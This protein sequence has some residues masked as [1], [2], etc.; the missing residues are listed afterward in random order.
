MSGNDAR[1]A[2]ASE[3]TAMFENSVLPWIRGFYLKQGEKA[4]RQ[5]CIDYCTLR[6]WPES[7]WPTVHIPASFVIDNDPRHAAMRQHIALPRA[8]MAEEQAKWLES[9]KVRSGFYLLGQAAQEPPAKRRCVFT[10]THRREAHDLQL[11]DT[12]LALVDAESSPE[13]QGAKR[14]RDQELRDEAVLDRF[15]AE[16]GADLYQMHVWHK[17]AEGQQLPLRAARAV[18]RAPA[19]HAGDELSGGAHGRHDQAAR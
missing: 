19:E 3:L 11:C 12:M 5:L 16:M 10:Y 18:G 2:V 7:E 14:K 8:N 6:G 13:L 15:A 4:M 17:R 9:E 1:S